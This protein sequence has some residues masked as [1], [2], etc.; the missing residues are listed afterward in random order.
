ML[1]CR[2][3][4]ADGCAELCASPLTFHHLP[5]HPKS[6]RKKTQINGPET[7]GEAKQTDRSD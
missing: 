1:E 4:R 5:V 7:L 6:G 3:Q 2:V